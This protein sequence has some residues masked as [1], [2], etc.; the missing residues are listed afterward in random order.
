MNWLML[1]KKIIVVCAEYYVKPIC[2]LYGQNA[3]LFIVKA[4]DTYSYSWALKAQ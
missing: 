3:E 4:D 2:K 1:F